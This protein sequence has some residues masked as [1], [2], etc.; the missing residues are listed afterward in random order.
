MEVVNHTHTMEC[1][2]TTHTTTARLNPTTTLAIDTLAHPH[3][4]IITAPPH[5]PTTTVPSTTEVAAHTPIAAC[6]ITIHTT[7]ARPNP[8]ITPGMPTTA[9]PHPLIPTAHTTPTKVDIPTAHT[10]PTTVDTHTRLSPTTIHTTTA[11]LNLTTT[12]L[13]PTIHQETLTAHTTP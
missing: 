13:T 6:L 7:I 5:L 4:H 12:P 1:P 2:T 8:T 9:H 10:T 3:H 11:K